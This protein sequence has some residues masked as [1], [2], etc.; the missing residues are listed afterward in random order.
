MLRQLEEVAP[1]S[2]GWVADRGRRALEAVVQ[3]D[4][5]G[6]SD[7]KAPGVAVCES[8]SLAHVYYTGFRGSLQLEDIVERYPGVIEAVARHPGIGFV[9]ASRLFGDAVALCDGGVRNLITGHVGEGCDPLAPYANRARWG[10]ELAELLSYPDSGD[11]V[12]HGAWL[13]EKQRIVVLEEQT[14]SHGGL[15]GPQTEP[16]LVAPAA[17]DVTDRDLDSPEGLYGLVSRQMGQYRPSSGAEK[18][19]KYAI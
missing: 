9:A 19:Q 15:G 7:R 16:F 17:W 1:S 12:I 14:S 6:G 11:L 8:G 5:P 18:G 2:P 10:A 4:L 13:E 3:D